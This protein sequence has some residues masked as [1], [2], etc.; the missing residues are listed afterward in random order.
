MG[1]M[2]T[3]AGEE[4]NHHDVVNGESL[5]EVLSQEKSFSEH[6]KELEQAGQDNGEEVKPLDETIK[7]FD[8]EAVLGVEVCK[9]MEAKGLPVVDLENVSATPWVFSEALN[10]GIDANPHGVM[11]WRR[12]P[13]EIAGDQL[14]VS[15]DRSAGVRV[16]K[17]GEI[18]SLFRNP[19]TST[20]RGILPSMMLSAIGVGG[21]KGECYGE[22]MMR[23]YMQLGFVP[24]AHTRWSEKDLQNGST[25]NDE[26]GHPDMYFFVLPKGLSL[27]K[28]ASGYGDRPVMSNEDLESLPILGY[29]G[30]TPEA[31][32]YRDAIL[33]GDEA[34]AQAILEKFHSDNMDGK[35]NA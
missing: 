35:F 2:Q 34:K 3:T 27:E 9:I 13:D 26:F 32:A 25:W 15:K 33:D 19:E 23:Q 18:G 29:D 8:E 12:T 31:Y 4:K 17:D 1:I 10:K 30:E 14:L 16:G 5:F 24:V 7:E 20:V 21:N 11:V 6:M 22:N 28:C